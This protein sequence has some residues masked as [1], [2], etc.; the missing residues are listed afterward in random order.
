MT[1]NC[2][3][4][5]TTRPGNSSA[6]CARMTLVSSAKCCSPLGVHSAGSRMTRGSTRGTFTMAMVFSRPNALRPPS[7]AM[8]FSDLLATCGNGCAGSSPTGTSSGRTSRSKKRSTHSRC[9]AV[10]SA[11]LAMRM[12]CRASD[13]IT[14]SL[15][16]AYCSSISP[17]ASEEMAIRSRIASPAPGMRAAS[18]ASA[19]RTSKNSSRLDDTIV[20]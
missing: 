9:L 19:K 18:S 4:D 12:P 15:K 6:R 20:T 10:R 13:G 11:W 7:L 5:S 17:W 2:E 14:C 16:M 8:K 3:N 1:R